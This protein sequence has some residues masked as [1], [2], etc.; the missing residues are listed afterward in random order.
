MDGRVDTSDYEES[1]SE[2][3]WAVARRLRHRT[4]VALEPWDLSPRWRVR[5][6]CWPATVTCG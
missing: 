2:A 5:S 6:A 3:F 4:R 1:L